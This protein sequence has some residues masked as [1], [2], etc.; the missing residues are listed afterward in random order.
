VIPRRRKNNGDALSCTAHQVGQTTVRRQHGDLGEDGSPARQP[1]RLLMM[2]GNLVKERT[3]NNRSPRR[4]P[5]IGSRA[6]SPQADG[7]AYG[8]LRARPAAR[9][10]A[11]QPIL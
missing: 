7:V 1:Q 8:D 9:S 2:N 10:A 6:G 5:G 4:R 3:Q 11:L